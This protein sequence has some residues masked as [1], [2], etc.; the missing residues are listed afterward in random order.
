MPK[1]KFL[2]FWCWA[3]LAST[4]ATGGLPLLAQDTKS[5]AQTKD[6]AKAP[7]ATKSQ[8]PAKPGEVAKPKDAP[9]PA[10]KPMLELTE[11]FRDPRVDD[12]LSEDL[13]KEL[14]APRPNFSANEERQVMLMAGGRG[15]SNPRQVS[16]FVE[17]KAAELTNRKAIEAMLSGEGNVNATV[18]TIESATQALINAS[19]A[20]N[21]ANNSPFMMTYTA[22]LVKTLQP[23]LKA[24]LITRVQ[25]AIVLASTGSGEVN[26][27]LLQILSDE[28]QPWQMKFIAVQGLNNSIQNDRRLTFNQRTQL[29]VAVSNLIRAEKESPWFIKEEA[30]NV[31]GNLRI[32]S[33]VVSAR[34]VEPAELMMELLT[35]DEERPEVRFAAGRALGMMEIPSQ[36]RP[37]NYQLVAASVGQSVLDTAKRVLG[38]TPTDSSRGQQLVAIM[39]ARLPGTFSG[40][41]GMT[42]SGLKRQATVGLA[43][44]EVKA[45]IDE[46]FAKTNNVVNA[47]SVYVKSRGDIIQARRTDLQTAILELEKTVAKLQP[48][49]RAL[50]K[51]G[52]TFEQNAPAESGSVAQGK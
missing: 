16:R 40:E 50:I 9:T 12:A 25:A 38:T 37:F 17:A 22:S 47:A 30:C 36:F 45:A 1:P 19:R 32:V 48:K 23:L 49:D 18:R 41:T 29:T 24:H 33:E 35:N 6:A 42:D 34:K 20:A 31:I 11:T 2:N 13:I 43:S 14:P 52:A 3:L 4:A 44:T 39:A 15:E 21:D 8:A 51:D 46:L 28:E 26:A 7:E 27:T 5:Q 10:T